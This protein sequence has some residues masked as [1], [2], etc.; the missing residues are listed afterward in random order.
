MIKS[1]VYHATGVTST[2]PSTPVVAQSYKVS[3]VVKG[4]PDLGAIRM[5]DDEPQVGQ[6]FYLED[7][8]F[9]IIKVVELMPPGSEFIYLHAVCRPV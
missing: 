9:K 7:T 2:N 8:P 5:M 6:T 4:R 3:I 1:E